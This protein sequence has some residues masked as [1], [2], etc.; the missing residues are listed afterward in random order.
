MPARSEGPIASHGAREARDQSPGKAGRPVVE[1][2]GKALGKIREGRD[3]ASRRVES[4]ADL[5]F[6]FAN[7]HLTAMSQ[8]MKAVSQWMTAGQEISKSLSGTSDLQPAK[9]DKRFRDPVWS[10]NP[11]YRALMQS[12]LAFSRGA[13][14]WVDS[15]GISDRDKLR[16]RLL[17]G[18]AVDA[19]APTN[20][21]LGNPAAMKATLEQGGENLWKGARQ[22]TRDM[23]ENG[24][25]PSMVDKSKFTVGG[26]LAV[27]EGH[28]VYAE[29][30]LELIQY[31]PKADR[32][33]GTPVFIV[34]PQINKFYVWDLA[35]GRSIVE[36]LLDQGHQVF[37]VSWR[38]PTA[39]QADWGL[40]SYIRALDR[41]SEAACEISG[42][43]QLNVVG[44]CSGGIT[45]ALLLS[46]WG[47]RG[48]T[49]A[50]SLSLLVAILDVSGGENT[51]MGLFANLETLEVAKLFSRSK[52]VLGGKDLERAFAWLR[53]N[54]L[55]WAYWVNNYLLGNEPAAF[56]ILYWNADTT[57]LPAALH[58]DL[59][60]LLQKGGVEHGGLVVDGYELDL[61]NVTCDA[62][63]VGG[64]TDHITPWDG[65]YLTRHLLGGESEFI[66]SQ[67]GH[68]Q[69]LINP[70]G[71]P[72]ARF[73]V[74][75]GEH[76]SAETFRAGARETEGSWWP[77]WQ[78]WLEARSGDRV[79]AR[80]RPGS[81]K[82]EPIC[83]AP[84]RYVDEAA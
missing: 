28:V 63:L 30:H 33:L 61:R 69:S 45:A 57:K 44:A 43:E 51:S 48:D 38:N 77:T 79:D 3:A 82:H 14:D 41:A 47:A 34:P 46:L 6:A 16:A 55:I 1:G 32:V 22:L 11:A 9:D 50:A 35:P 60:R 20:F 21:L 29:D 80:A 54:D 83:E 15:L 24:G 74:N 17:T 40:A 68:I 8:P 18:L 53:P 67:S 64:E 75:Y 71:N 84:G 58:G 2:F 37:I 56:D 36:Y 66:L 59:L 62:F 26:N 70:P 39:A 78:G 13:C 10:S 42:S 12:Y 5:G 76:D 25:L 7:F 23:I 52:G 49:R 27:S 73:L 81:A 19:V 65:C 72:K 31:A 4:A